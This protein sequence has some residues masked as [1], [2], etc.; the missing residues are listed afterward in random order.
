MQINPES[1]RAPSRHKAWL[2]MLLIVALGALLYFPSFAAD[3]LNDE[4]GRRALPAREMLESGDFVVPTLWGEPYLNKPPLYFWLVAAASLVTDGVNEASTRLPSVLAT[5]LTALL[6]YLV[7][8]W[9]RGPT[10]GLVA[11]LLYL[12][13]FSVI[14]KGAFGELEAVFTLA[15]FA[16]MAAIYGASR[17]SKWAQAGVV[18][19]L[20]A[21]LL[22]KGP[23]AFVFFGAAAIAIAWSRREAR[24]L[25]SR[26]FWL[27]TL[28]ATL[29]AS[30]WVWLL[31]RRPEVKDALDTWGS[32][33]ARGR[34]A[35]FSVYLH[36]RKRL[37]LGVLTGFFPA[38]LILL[39]AFR[40][41]VARRVWE[42]PIM[43]FSAYTILIG[44]VFFGLMP[45]TRVRYVHP[46]IPWAVLW[47]SELLVEAQR[48]GATRF[49][50]RT[51]R[52][53]RVLAC[54]GLAV[55]GGA[56]WLQFKSI[57]DLEPFGTIG[58]LLIGCLLLVS[59]RSF[60]LWKGALHSRALWSSFALLAL[61]RLV[62]LNEIVPQAAD[63][64]GRRAL[65]ATIADPLPE[66]AALYIT[67]G[68]HYKL[69]FYVGH[70]VKHLLDPR[71]APKGA[72]VLLPEAD[73]ARLEQD[74]NLSV[75]P[76]IQ[77]E[78][79]EGQHLSLVQI[80][81]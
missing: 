57:A 31:L 9:S 21:A 67:G 40:T 33:M 46:L 59:L 60:G 53:G 72:Y 16:C 6:L 8:R 3:E 7:G 1:N 27:P 28:A 48:S 19:G 68:F 14:E 35:D 18:L 55:V 76:I 65:A 26:I 50:T 13:T 38:S 4:E 15:L 2:S 61:L 69:L 56:V 66:G 23:P 36:D 17:G 25:R 29:L 54:L 24:F 42:Q 74:A 73:A 81:P 62:Q 77:I 70:R 52:V 64:H 12:V 71:K 78:K 20:C 45:G 44:L 22:I 75:R 30:I 37:F 10:T 63:R 5:I 41:D 43:R 51:A 11:G 80:L 39:M 32:Q 47:A 34:G 58:W 49:T 79:A